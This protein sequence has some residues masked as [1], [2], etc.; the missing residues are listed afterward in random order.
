MSSVMVSLKE[1]VTIAF[2]IGLKMETGD[3]TI[4]VLIS[5]R[6]SLEGIFLCSL[7]PPQLVDLLL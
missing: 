3:A 2:D 5:F 7:L 1:E 6:Q 4:D